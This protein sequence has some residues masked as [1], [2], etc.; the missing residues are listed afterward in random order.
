MR[1]STQLDSVKP[2]DRFFGVRG[3]VRQ[4]EAEWE[5]MRDVD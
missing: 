1:Q 3:L 5:D 2:A 4:A